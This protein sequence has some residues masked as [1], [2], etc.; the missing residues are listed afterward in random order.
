MHQYGK[1]IWHTNMTKAIEKIMTE[2]A[3]LLQYD[4]FVTNPEVTYLF[5]KH[6]TGIHFSRR[7]FFDIIMVFKLDKGWMWEEDL[8][9]H[10]R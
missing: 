10:I 6:K 9:V 7:T 2:D 3:I 4:G 8:N 1:E 5:Q